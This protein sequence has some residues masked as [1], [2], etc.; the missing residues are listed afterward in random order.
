MWPLEKIWCLMFKVDRCS[1]YP[2]SLPLISN[3][4]VPGHGK[5]V[6]C[7]QVFNV[8]RCSIW[9][10]PLYIYIYIIY[11]YIYIYNIY[12]YIYILYILYIY[13]YIY[14]YIYFQRDCGSS[15]RYYPIESKVS[16]I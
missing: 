2:G 11:I 16:A 10:V 9:Q 8:H 7:T 1:M 6:Q 12:I 13:I 5:T 14:V 15:P 3:G 4:S